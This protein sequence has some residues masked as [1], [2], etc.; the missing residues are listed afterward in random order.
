MRQLH[1][2]D[3]DYADGEGYEFEPYTEFLSESETRDWIRAWTGNSES[4][5]SDFRVFG[6]DGT[7]GYAAF[8]LVRVDVPL[9]EQPI[10]FLGSEGARGL[11]A[12]NLA[13]YLW[14]LAGG[15]G[16]FEA[17]EEPNRVAASTELSAAF[18]RFA[19]HHAPGAKRE[20]SEILLAVQRE[21]PT[22]TRY[23][24]EMCR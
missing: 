23:I 11:V 8:W 3:F 16:P 24:D 4:D 9:V 13:D 22:F 2:I 20:P 14:V 7:G 1:E 19:E 17:V 12:R 5:G 10:V 15:L 6:Q 21:F 18:R